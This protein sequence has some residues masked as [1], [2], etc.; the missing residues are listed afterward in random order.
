MA[1]LWRILPG[2]QST[3]VAVHLSWF[4]E[5]VAVRDQEI[6]DADSPGTAVATDK[7]LCYVPQGAGLLEGREI[8]VIN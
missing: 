6:K 1:I 7:H 2:S 5:D 3:A 8:P 4:D